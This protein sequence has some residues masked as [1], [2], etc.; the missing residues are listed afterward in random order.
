MAAFQPLI[1]DR[2]TQLATGIT[3]IQDHNDKTRGNPFALIINSISQN[4]KHEHTDGSRLSSKPEVYNIEA[5]AQ[6]ILHSHSPVFSKIGIGINKHDSGSIV[7]YLEDVQKVTRFINQIPNE[8]TVAEPVLKL[9]AKGLETQICALVNIEESE[10][11]EDALGDL[12]YLYR[13]LRS[14]GLDKELKR[15]NNLLNAAEGDYLSEQLKVDDS[16]ILDSG[17]GPKDWHKDSTAPRLYEKWNEALAVLT[18]I[19]DNPK[20]DSLKMR[21]IFAL[22]IGLESFE[23]SL[24]TWSEGRFPYANGDLKDYVGVYR[25]IKGEFRQK[26]ENW[27][28]I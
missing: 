19:H 16:R 2:L 12:E 5:N 24:K 22:G 8:S 6:E 11:R 18:D 14:R 7:Y 27:Q 25:L 23:A 9:V 3:E 10:H 21:V 15:S 17:F 26:L 28:C 1:N 4:I 20:G 13:T